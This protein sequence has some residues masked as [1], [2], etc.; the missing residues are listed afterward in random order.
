MAQKK[1]KEMNKIELQ[2][3][4]AERYRKQN[5]A[6]SM[7]YDRISVVLPIGTKKRIVAT[8]EKINEFASSAIL[9]ALEQSEGLATTQDPDPDPEQ[10]NDLPWNNL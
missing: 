2:E 9:A 5:A 6:A 10:P 8:G 3:Y 4:F 1:I 7:R